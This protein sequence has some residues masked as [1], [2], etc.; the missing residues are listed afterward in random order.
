MF[1]AVRQNKRIS[2]VILAI[3]I[4]PF[5]FFGMDAYFSDSPGAR[6]VATV[7]GSKIS[8]LEFEQALRDQQDR[9]REATGGQF[10]RALIE[11]EVFRRSVLENLINQRLLALHVQD[12]RIVVTPQQLQEVIGSLPGFQEDGRF[13]LA[14]YE[15]LVRSQGMSPAMF[16]ARLAQDLRIQQVAQAVGDSVF[17]ARESAR[18]LVAAQLEEREFRELHFPAERFLDQV[19]VGE[20]A[21]QAFYENNPARFERAP[22]LKA[23]Y[24]VFDENVLLDRVSVADEAV[25]QFYDANQERFGVPEERRARHILIQAAPG[26]PEAERVEARSK[27]EALLAALRDDP[28]RFEELARSESQDPGSATAGGD[29]GFFGLGAM[30]KPFEDAVFALEEGAISDVVQTDFGFHIIQVTG[31]NPSTIRSLDEARDEILAELRRQEAG[32]QFATL[33]EQFANTV[34]EQHDSLQP[35]ADL[36]GIDIRQSDWISRTGGYVGQF[37]NERLIDALFADEAVKEGHNTEAIEVERGVLISAR[38]VEFEPGQ[39]LPL[40]AVRESIQRELR[41]AEAARLA[42]ESGE[43]ALVRLL[44]GE[45]VEGEWGSPRTVQ[46]VNPLLAPAAMQAVFAAPTAALPAHVGVALPGVY[47]LYRIEGVTRP[48]LAADDPRVIEV[49]LQYQQLLAQK[50]FNAYL[51]S[52]RDRYKVEI[53]AAALRGTAER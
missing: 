34:Y 16:E 24:L 13:S 26:A 17:A 1:E 40:D 19:E 41:E 43:A 20:G 47:T 42:R 2:Q 7:G 28:A 30:V 44:G 25:R 49:G 27:A 50:D 37:Q 11:S 22:R 18:R 52:L 29:L 9:I 51:A 36:L 21:V 35:A 23:E 8:V 38:V 53:S 6:E 48:E 39:K 12:Q 5:A 46:R 15:M 31:I 3:I 33:A 4:V 14:R 10:D 32:R 45:E